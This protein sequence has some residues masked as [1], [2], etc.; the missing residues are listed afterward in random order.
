MIPHEVEFVSIAD[1]WRA[2][3]AA[4][5][6]FSYDWNAYLAS[7]DASALAT[8]TCYVQNNSALRLVKIQ[9]AKECVVFS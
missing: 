8:P 3:T 7:G 5:L 4:P 9:D 2:I 1:T 6:N